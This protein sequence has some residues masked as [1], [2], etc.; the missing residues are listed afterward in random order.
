MKRAIAEENAPTWNGIMKKYANIYIFWKE[1][2]GRVPTE[3]LCVLK[4]YD[5]LGIDIATCTLMGLTLTL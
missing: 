4:C 1:V 2:Y 5:D 3:I